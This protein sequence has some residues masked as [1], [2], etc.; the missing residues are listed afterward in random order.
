[1]VWSC[2]K[3]VYRCRVKTLILLE[4]TDTSREN[5]IVQN[6][7]KV[8]N[9]TDMIALDRTEWKR[10]IHVANSN[11]HQNLMMMMTMTMIMMMMIKA[12]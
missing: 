3:E 9:L 10:K 5:E 12:T 6:N 2:P 11:W 8:L 7:L 4:I 1:M